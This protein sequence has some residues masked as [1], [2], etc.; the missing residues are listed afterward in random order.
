MVKLILWN[1]IDERTT[2]R[3]KISNEAIN[4]ALDPAM[5]ELERARMQVV[6]DYLDANKEINSSIAAKLL[7]VEIKTASQS[8]L[9]EM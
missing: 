3:N 7:E 6:L 8:C 5:S 9:G 1:N 2:Y 4:N